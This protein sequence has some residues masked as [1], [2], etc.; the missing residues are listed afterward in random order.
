[1]VL[2]TCSH[3]L[4]SLLQLCEQLEVS[5]HLCDCHNAGLS[6]QVENGG[7]SMPSCKRMELVRLRV[8]RRKVFGVEVMRVT[9]GAQRGDLAGWKGTYRVGVC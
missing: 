1:M 6:S 4:L 3:A 2:L 7:C 9:T 8:S 5:G